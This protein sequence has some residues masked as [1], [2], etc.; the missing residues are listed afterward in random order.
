MRFPKTCVM[1]VLMAMSLI[2]SSH[3]FAQTEDMPDE[4]ESNTDQVSVTYR[5]SDVYLAVGTMLDMTSTV[6]L[7][8]HPTIAYRGDGSVLTH[9]H[10]IEAG[11]ARVFGDRNEFTAVAA[12][13][14]LNVGLNLLSRKIYR[15]GGY[16]RV[17]AIG[18]NV[19]K[20]TDNLVAGI[21]NIRYN[22]DRNVRSVTGYSGPIHWSHQ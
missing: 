11:W 9:Y 19:L 2:H 1:L 21:H 14:G 8:G 5:V 20:G 3:A 6:R 17:L 7:M 15:R 16:W 12:N 13:V 22:A 10:G 18:M 4:P